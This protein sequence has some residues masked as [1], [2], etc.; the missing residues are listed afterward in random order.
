MTTAQFSVFAFLNGN[1]DLLPL[2]HKG[3]R[4]DVYMFTRRHDITLTFI[5]H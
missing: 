1:I 2:R 3:L 5:R 4:V